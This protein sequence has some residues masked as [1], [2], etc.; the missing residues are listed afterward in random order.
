MYTDLEVLSDFTDQPLE[1]EL[2]D[3]QLRGLL[4]PT[5]LTKSDSTRPE[6]MGL[7]HTT[8]CGLYASCMGENSMRA[9][10][11]ALTAAVLRAALAASCLR[12]ALPPVD[13]RAVCLV[14]AIVVV[15]VEGCVERG[16]VE[17][18]S[19]W[20]GGREWWW[21]RREGGDGVQQLAS[22]VYIVRTRLHVT[23]AQFDA[24]VAVGA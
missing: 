11:Q 21:S 7:L 13:L 20:R 2:A 1:G 10:Y 15:E 14:R 8:S 19:V 17:G 23:H 5:N 18:R 12:G 24:T 16:R 9:G 6:T 4:V 3:E 22:E